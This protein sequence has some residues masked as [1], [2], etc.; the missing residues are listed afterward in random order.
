MAKLE[1][2]NF[3]QYASVKSP[4][5]RELDHYKEFVDILKFISRNDCKEPCRKD[6]GCG[7]IPCKIM[8]CAEEKNYEGCWECADFKDCEKFDIV[9]PR[10]G[11]TPYKNLLKIKELGYKDWINERG[12]Y[13][14]WQRKE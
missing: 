13:Y 2:V 5:G 4:F 14:I 7:G 9:I 12:P 10:C 1:Q 6:G 3:K 8:K 11:D